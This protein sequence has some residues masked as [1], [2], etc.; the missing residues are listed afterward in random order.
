MKRLKLAL[1][2]LAVAALTAGLYALL[3]A[4]NLSNRDL[5][6]LFISEA[7]VSVGVVTFRMVRGRR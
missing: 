1:R 6:T 2:V 7:A 5:Y 4:L 3:L